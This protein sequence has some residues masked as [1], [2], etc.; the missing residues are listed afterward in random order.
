MT[1]SLSMI[2]IDQTIVSVALPTIQRDVNTSSV[3]AQWIINAYLLALAALV[4]AGG[5]AGDIFGRRR[6][7]IIG[8]VLFAGFSALCGAADSEGWLIAS[9]VGQGVGGAL[10]MPATMALVVTA[11]PPEDRGKAIGILVGVA[12]VFLSVGPLLGG[13]FTEGVSWRWVFF[14]NLP[15]AALTLLLA[16]RSTPESRDERVSSL[17]P[18]GFVTVAVGLTALVLALMEGHQ[19]GCGSPATLALLVGSAVLLAAFTAF[20]LRHGQPLVDLRCS[21]SAP[22]RAATSWCHARNSRS[23]VSRFSA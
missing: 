6:T 4:A 3:E 1:C 20:E 9:R 17:D 21:G 18:V 10:M 2:F 15:V 13:I 12:S 19:W 22:S 23:S 8:T 5:R 14:V 11:F 7:W 16:R